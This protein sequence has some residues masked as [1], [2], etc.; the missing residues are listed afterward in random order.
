MTRNLPAGCCAASHH[1]GSARARGSL[2]RS[3]SRASTSTAY[4]RKSGSTRSRQQHAAVGVR[5][6]AHPALALRGELGELG[7]SRP[8]RRRAPSARSSAATSSTTRCS[9]LVARPSSGPDA[10]ATSLRPSGRRPLSGRSSPSGC[11]ARSSASGPLRFAAVTRARVWIAAISSSA[12]PARRRSADGRPPAPRRR[13]AGDGS[14]VAVALEQRH[15]LR[16]R[17]CARARS[18]SR[19]CSRSDA[20]SAAPRRRCAG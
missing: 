12:C 2:R 3:P 19:S 5:V 8:S 18:G 6:R 1:G 13:T 20:G 15:Q 11:A 10:T 4:S 16:P 17:E 14:A 7:D 9:A